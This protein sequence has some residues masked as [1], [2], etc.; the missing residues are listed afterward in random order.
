M[1]TSLAIADMHCAACV[2][3]V[4]AALARVPNVIGCEVNPVRREVFIEHEDGVRSDELIS[5]IVD[6]GFSASLLSASLGSSDEDRRLLSRLGIAGLAMMQVMMVSVALYAGG[7]YGMEE[8]FRQL[9]QLSSLIFCIPVVSYCALPFFTSALSCLGV[10]GP[11]RGLN[12]DVPIALAIA[13]A[14]SASLVATFKGTGEVYFDSV[15]M[16]TF[17]MLGAR[18]F[19]ARLRNSLTISDGVLASLPR[20]AQ[21]RNADGRWQPV[22]LKELTIGDVLWIAEGELI[23]VDGVID[24]SPG[25]SDVA[26]DES[27]LTGESA[28]ARRSVGEAVYAG[29][30]NLGA[31]FSLAA[32]TTASATRLAQ[33]D[34]LA[35]T[36][37]GGKHALVRLADRVARVFVP[38]VLCLAAATYIGWSLVDPGRA[39]SAALA[40]L[41]VSCPC[42][43]AL[44][45]PAALTAAM[46]S[47]RQKGVLVKN[48][49][50]LESVSAIRDVY[51]DKTGT[52]TEPLLS[53]Q[54]IERYSNVDEAWLRG[55]VAALQKHSSHPFATA[56][57]TADA[58]Q[59]EQVET[60]AGAGISGVVDGRRIQ[61][62]SADFVSAQLASTNVSAPSTVSFFVRIDQKLAARIDLA[63]RLR[64]DAR[65]T[66]SELARLGI[67]S[68]I[69]SGDDDAH[70]RAVATQLDIDYIAGCTPESKAERLAD[71]AALFVGDG[72]ND[73]PA[74]A[75][76]AVSAATLETSDLVKSRADVLLLSDRLGALT[77][78]VQVGRRMLTIM[79]Q[80]LL[81][82]ALYNLT[83]I[84]LA[85]FGFAPPWL[86]AI[87]MASS[88]L[89]VL[90]NATRVLRDQPL[91]PGDEHTLA[92][93][94]AQGAG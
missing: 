16:F 34:E 89:L 65:S 94:T 48:S 44:A 79:R 12:M 7:F 9:L 73:V 3:K 33:I 83:A 80:N 32:T 91:P 38:V 40:V 15:V 47:L 66:I 63:T 2:G 68:V 58:M 50:A 62:G 53:I 19:D 72:I 22:P 86:A 4:E 23:P 57:R 59:A 42:A 25:A 39:L 85:A 64:A 75:G 17:L 54:H 10:G 20:T 43:L 67:R 77:S 30:I 76:A 78:L 55:A 31:G 93:A 37:H 45:S 18:Y 13:V 61:V 8:H 84:P 60:V 70:C 46:S 88:S 90:A 28:I 87:G 56:F 41:V 92:L 27:V 82:A 69:L 5:R 52:L 51:F 1:I 14:F 74:L 6:A 36:L 35:K 81:W 29:T 24:E 21:R 71:Q 11:A 26:L 49:A